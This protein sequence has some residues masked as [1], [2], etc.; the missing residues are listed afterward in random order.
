MTY[1]DRVAS[2]VNNILKKT[3]SNTKRI[4]NHTEFLKLFQM[5]ELSDQFSIQI[6]GENYS[7]CKQMRTTKAAMKKNSNRIDEIKD[8]L[9]KKN[10]SNSL[11]DISSFIAYII[12]N[13][14][15]NYTE[16]TNTKNLGK[17]SIYINHDSHKSKSNIKTENNTNYKTEDNTTVVETETD[18]TINLSNDTINLSN[19]NVVDSWEDL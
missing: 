3:M 8:F 9:S 12:C 2:N 15:D 1:H 13:M 19:D 17:T 11:E 6:E 14:E 18:D 7:R 4:K 5:L 10:K 16:K